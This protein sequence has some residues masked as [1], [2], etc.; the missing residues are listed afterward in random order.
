MTWETQLGRLPDAELGHTGCQHGG[1]VV[2]HAPY[3]ARTEWLALAP[4]PAPHASPKLIR[5]CTNHAAAFAH[6]VGLPFPPGH[7]KAGKLGKPPLVFE[8]P[9][10]TPAATCGSCR[11]IIRWIVTPKGARMPVD[12]DGVSHFVTCVHADAHRRR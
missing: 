7:W 11:A 8:I 9:E 5:Y 4:V 6:R 10:G 3:L 2:V 1:C 12:L